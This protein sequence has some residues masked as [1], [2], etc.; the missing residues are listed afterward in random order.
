M[1]INLSRPWTHRCKAA[2]VHGFPYVMNAMVRPL[3]PLPMGAYCLLT[4]NDD[5]EVHLLTSQKDFKIALWAL[6]SYYVASGRRDPLLV[7]DDGSLS[8]RQTALFERYFPHCHVIPRCV[9]DQMAER[10]LAKWPL[11][12]RFRQRITTLLKLTDPLLFGTAKRIVLFDSDQLFFEYPAALLEGMSDRPHVFL[13]D[14]RST[15]VVTPEEASSRFGVA[16]AERIACGLANVNRGAVDFDYLETVLARLMAEKID[17]SPLVEQTLW[18][19]E[20]A[21]TGFC[22]LP[23]TYEIAQA[24]QERWTVARHYP[25][26]PINRWVTARDYFYSEGIPRVKVMLHEQ[27]TICIEGCPSKDEDATS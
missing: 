12:H 11:L 14:L 4:T 24:P 23:A 20:C 15:Y 17:Y 1:A 16:L 22:R 8:E 27:A 6:L 10:R 3:P 21:R 13:D 25:N 26:L 18:A 19:A 5:I 9:A 2:L 7:H